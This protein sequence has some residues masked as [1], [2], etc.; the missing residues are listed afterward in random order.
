MQADLWTFA[1]S[2]YQRSTVADDCL[3]LQAQGANV[4]LL[5]CAAWLEHGAVDCTTDRV[6]AL[7]KV[8]LQWS[9]GVIEPLRSLRQQWRGAAQQDAELARLREAV[10]DL[11]LQAEK[12][13]LTRLAQASEGWPRQERSTPWLEAMAPDGMDHRDALLRLRAAVPSA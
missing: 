5:L 8:A 13:L 6:A 10:K 1:V 9:P 7:Q 4:C 2:L 12:I 3:A 11:E